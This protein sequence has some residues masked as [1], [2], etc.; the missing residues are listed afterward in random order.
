MTQTIKLSTQMMTGISVEVTV[1]NSYLPSTFD[2]T[3][4]SENEDASSSVS[5]SVLD[6]ENMAPPKKQKGKKRIRKPE[7]WKKNER[8][9]LRNSGKEYVSARGKTVKERVMGPVCKCRLTCPIKIPEEIRKI[10]FKDYWGLG[11]FQ[12]QRD[13]LTSCIDILLVEPNPFFINTLRIKER[14]VRTIIESKFRGIG[15]TPIDK[16]GKNKPISEKGE[17]MEEVI[18]VHI[19]SIP[20]LENHYVRANTNQEFI[21]INFFINKLIQSFVI[22]FHNVIIEKS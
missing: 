3:D 7:S 5:S 16:R 15:A 17:E 12:R 18:R 8:K 21:S 10:L 4:T 6:K 20:R 13:Y 19:N 1:M 11:L 2:S 9:C 14:T 22:P